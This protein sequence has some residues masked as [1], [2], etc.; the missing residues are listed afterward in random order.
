VAPCQ[1]NI[2]HDNK[3]TI[4]ELS[5]TLEFGNVISVKTQIEQVL[6]GGHLLVII[7][8][9]GV[10]HA[11]SDGLGSIISVNKMQT[12]HG[13]KIMMI[14]VHGKAAEVIHTCKLDEILPI[15]D[16]SLEEAKI[17]ILE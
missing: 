4:I 15:S 1:V 11:N 14:N 8:F 13:A 9:Q 12:T 5:G 3:V 17:A 7:D 10:I 16:L 6:K 2:E